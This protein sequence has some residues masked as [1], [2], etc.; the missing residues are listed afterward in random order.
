MSDT[1]RLDTDLEITR[2]ILRRWHE[3]AAPRAVYSLFAR[4]LLS[5]RVRTLKFS[6]AS[7]RLRCK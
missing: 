2:A 4:V 7:R 1:T 5:V 3:L 6:E